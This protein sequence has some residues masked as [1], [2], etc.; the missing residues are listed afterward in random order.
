MLQNKELG[1]GRGLGEYDRV[2]YGSVTGWDT[3][4]GGYGIEG[5]KGRWGEFL[6][7]GSWIRSVEV[8]NLMAEVWGK[9]NGGK[10]DQNES[11][12]TSVT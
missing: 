10:L 12:D 7:A 8:E 11:F 9:F 1:T 6:M 5:N 2:G 4:F 3:E